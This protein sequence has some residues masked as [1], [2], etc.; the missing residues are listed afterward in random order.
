MFPSKYFLS[1]W[2]CFQ[3]REAFK[4]Q[5]D[6]R[7]EWKILTGGAVLF[8]ERR[9]RAHAHTVSHTGRRMADSE[10]LLLSFLLLLSGT[11]K[12]FKDDTVFVA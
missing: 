12:A 7:S 9:T 3:V 6:E 1:A 10:K 11:R 4:N 8:H 2:F 5:R